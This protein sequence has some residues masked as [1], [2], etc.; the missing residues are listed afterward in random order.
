MVRAVNNMMARSR[1]LERSFAARN[2]PIRVA[3]RDS[4]GGSDV[5]LLKDPAHVAVVG[6]RVREGRYREGD[7][8][9]PQRPR[10]EGLENRMRRTVEFLEK[11]EKPE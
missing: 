10:G 9:T 6:E 7:E 5:R 2:L 8:Q 1:D 4:I 3:G 11:S